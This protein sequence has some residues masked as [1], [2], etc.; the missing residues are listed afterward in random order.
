MAGR[1]RKTV[2]QLKLTGSY[3]KDRYGKRNETETAVAELSTF[4]AGQ[5]LEPPENITDDFVKNYYRYHTKL[6]IQLGIL[7]PSDIPE[8]NL[9]YETL[10]TERNVQAQLQKVDITKDLKT[11]TAL[12]KIL[13]K[14]I[15]TFSS[16]AQ[17]YYISPSSRTHLELDNLELQKK[18]IENES[19]VSKI[20]SNKK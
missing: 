12:A 3:R 14:L 15:N 19:I 5:S 16:L 9:M 7:Q 2:A 13:I 1:P 8:L 20:I 18:K 4:T 17:K 6:L 10:Q 11:Y